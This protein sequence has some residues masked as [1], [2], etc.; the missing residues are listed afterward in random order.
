MFIGSEQI[1]L[2]Q[3]LESETSEKAVVSNV[4]P[5]A[6]ASVVVSDVKIAVKKEQIVDPWTVESDETIDYD[7]LIQ[8]F[9][10]QRLTIDLVERIEKL[11]G[12]KAHRFLRR[13]IF[14]SHRDLKEMLD[15]YEAGKKFYLYTG[16]GPSSESLHLGHTIP[17]HFTKW[18]QDA[19]DCPLVIQLT[20]DEKFLFKPELK[21]EECHR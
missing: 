20:D 9:G 18:L 5:A 7:K 13:E 19:F 11:T 16:R 21:L 10:S 8:Q 6:A 4:K 17:F 1:N 15:L 3:K 14:F 2:D 12:K